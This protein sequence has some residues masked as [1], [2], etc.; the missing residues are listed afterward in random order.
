MKTVETQTEL[1]L[2]DSAFHD[3][4]DYMK[5][6]MEP[7]PL[8]PPSQPPTPNIT[9]WQPPV[10]KQQPPPSNEEFDNFYNGLEKDEYEVY[11]LKHLYEE[12]F[13]LDELS[14]YSFAGLKIIREHFTKTTHT[15]NMKR[16]TIYHK[17]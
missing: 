2:L 9:T 8:Q 11:E 16:M 14:I 5:S 1:A 13:H 3:W 10:I 6:N 17:K 15:R 7:P 4:I 12:F